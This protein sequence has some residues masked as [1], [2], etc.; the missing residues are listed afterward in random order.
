MKEAVLQRIQDDG[1]LLKAVFLP[2]MGMNLASLRFG[3]VEI[4]DQSTINIF[5]EKLGGLGALIGP[6]FHHRKEIPHIP[7]ETAFPHI[8]RV[9][10]SGSDEPFSHGIGRYVAWNWNASDLSI[11]ANISGMDTHAGVTLAALEGF[12]FKMSFKAHLLNDGIEINMHVDSEKMPSIAGL[13]YYYALDNGEGVVKM[14]V[15][16][17]YN[18]MGV[19]R[20]IPDKWRNT[21]KEELSFNLKE[22]SDYGFKPNRSD[23]SGDAILET[24]SRQLHIHYET[25]SE[26]NAFQLYSPDKATFVCIEPVT[27]SNPR[28]AKQ[29][30]NHLKVRIQ[31]K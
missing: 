29:L 4:I 11:D 31:L 3:D 9:K 6:H 15:Q 23:F 14:K 20:E 30:Q 10:A 28:D 2:E 22:K 24:G 27:A 7:D 25:D 13:H 21:E 26:E 18:D 1:N 16:D 5:N 8:A 19:W 12:D 17:T